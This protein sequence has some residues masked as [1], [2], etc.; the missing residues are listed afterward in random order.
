MKIKFFPF[1]LFFPIFVNAGS[2]YRPKSLAKKIAP[3]SEL[4]KNKQPKPLTQLEATQELFRILMDFNRQEKR[5]TLKPGE[6]KAVQKLIAQG[7]NLNTFSDEII[8]AS[9]GFFRNRSANPRDFKPEFKVKVTPLMLACYRGLI[10]VVKL[11]LSNGANVNARDLTQE[12]NYYQDT[13]LM[14][15]ILGSAYFELPEK[16]AAALIVKLCAYGASTSVNIPDPQGRTPLMYAARITDPKVV[17]ALLE[18]GADFRARDLNGKIPSDYAR[19][20]NT[21]KI[22]DAIAEIRRAA[23]VKVPDVQAVGEK[24][25]HEDDNSSNGPIIIPAQPEIR[26]I[27]ADFLFGPNA[28]QEQKGA[29]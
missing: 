22:I 4:K 11:L 12:K 28:G 6:L 21:R 14:L 2:F 15:A 8:L 9:P 3:E 18:C 17:Q 29:N 26:N 27:I 10:D 19:D 25:D 24:L 20:E 13:P 23:K 7:A 16:D 1:L 5:H